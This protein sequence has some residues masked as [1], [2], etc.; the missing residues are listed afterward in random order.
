[1]CVQ[2]VSC[3]QSSPDGEKARPGL[4]TRPITAG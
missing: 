4:L 3:V 2:M 1:M